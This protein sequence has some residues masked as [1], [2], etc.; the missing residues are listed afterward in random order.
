MEDPVLSLEALPGSW[1]D[2]DDTQLLLAVPCVAGVLLSSLLLSLCQPRAPQPVGS[3]VIAGCW[4]LWL[5]LIASVWICW[6][7]HPAIPSAFIEGF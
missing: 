7:L 5:Q 6:A 2:T 4:F 3:A 1:R